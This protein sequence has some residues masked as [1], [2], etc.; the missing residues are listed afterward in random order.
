[1]IRQLALFLALAGAA[2]AAPSRQS[3]PIEPVAIPP[4][5]QQ[6]IDLLYVDPGLAPAIKERDEL[7]EELGI[8]DTPGAA[9]DLFAPVS[10]IYTELRHAL[11]RYRSTWSSLPQLRLEAGPT[12]RKGAAG[13]RV[14]RLRGT[15]R[16]P[17]G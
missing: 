15:T 7:L 14:A 1:M 6:G 5:I 17:G 2:N 16:S 3:Y 8:A 10:P 11:A 9:V 12:L 13:E 4:S